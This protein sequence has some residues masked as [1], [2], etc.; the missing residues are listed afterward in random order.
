MYFRTFCFFAVSVP[1][2]AQTNNVITQPGTLLQ[3]PKAETH[4]VIP[5]PGLHYSF[6]E[7]LHDYV[8][9]L[10]G[11]TAIGKTVVGA[12]F[13]EMIGSNPPEWG[14]GIAGFGKSVGFRYLN[15]VASK[16]IEFGVGAL[17]GEDPRYYP[18]SDTTF[19]G[20]FEHAVKS[21]FIAPVDGGGQRFAF[22]RFAGAYGGAAVSNLWYP[23]RMRGMN[24]TLSKGSSSIATD[25]GM[26][27]FNEFWP[28]IKHKLMKR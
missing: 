23:A 19:W 21:T 7:R 27:L 25:V 28:D 11:P 17:I 10:I 15:R 14:D 3:L 22:A 24:H 13:K 8:N 2:L 1:V 9:S 16:S 26:N 18:S 4:I 5:Q 12:G 6:D 20:R